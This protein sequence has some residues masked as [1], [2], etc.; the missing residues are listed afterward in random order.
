MNQKIICLLFIL[1]L[2]LGVNAQV[3]IG[4]DIAPNT[5]ALLDLKENN[6][7]NSSRGLLMPRVK[8]SETKSALPM[9]THVAGMTIYNTATNADVTPGYYYND[10]T[11]WLR[12]STGKAKAEVFHMPSFLLPTGTNDSAYDSTTETF[13]V[14]LYDIYAKQYNLSETASSTKS[15]SASTLPVEAKDKLEYFITYYDNAV[16]DVVMVSDDGVLTYK[17]VKDYTITSKTF[18]NIVFKIK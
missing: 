2:C 18:M 13:T 3:T 11:K 16:F 1:I 9:S 12:L 7:G 14:K 17:L 5:N 10:G 6:I 8:L 15:P 4:S